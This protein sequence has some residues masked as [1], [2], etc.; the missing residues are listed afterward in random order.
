MYI[1]LYHIIWIYTVS[2]HN[3]CI[4]IYIY[5]L[6]YGV[7]VHMFIFH[8][9]HESNRHL[10]T[11]CVG[12]VC[13]ATWSPSMLPSVPVQAVGE[14]RWPCWQVL[15]TAVSQQAWRNLG[16]KLL[17]SGCYTPWI[18]EVSWWGYNDW[19]S[20]GMSGAHTS[21]YL[22]LSLAILG[23]RSQDG[24]GRWSQ[25][26]LCICLSVVFFW[27]ADQNRAASVT[28][29]FPVTVHHFPG[30]QWLACH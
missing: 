29:G 8:P 24:D 27:G 3:M 4:Y 5:K 21:L 15:T 13:S 28:P 14:W 1:H 16:Q 30:I 6:L 20:L 26:T 19:N 23:I 7:Y 25:W 9:N 17:S 12:K 10:W 22:G 2:V 18:L 11:C